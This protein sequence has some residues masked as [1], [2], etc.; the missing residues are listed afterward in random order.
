VWTGLLDAPEKL[1]H[2]RVRPRQSGSEIRR[3][4][5]LLALLRPPEQL[6]QTHSHRL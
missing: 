3:E 4:E 6:H 1:K 5:A 2:D